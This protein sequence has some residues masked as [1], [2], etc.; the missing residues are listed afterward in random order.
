[1]HAYE[2]AFR[3]AYK[4]LNK[5]QKQAVDTIEGPV[6]VIAGPGTGKTQVLSL[7][8]ANIL[9]ETQTPPDGILCLTFTN[10]GVKAMR[11]RLRG[12]IGGTA[13]R[14]VVSTFHTFGMQLIEEF[15]TDLGF[16]YA[17]TLID[18]MQSVALVDT[19]LRSHDW[20][21]IRTRS[22]PAMYFRDIKSL[23]SLLKR[24]RMTPETFDAE[25]ADEIHFLETDEGSIS[26][27]GPSKGQL[28]QEIVK[29]IESLKRTREIVQFY[30]LYEA[31][32]KEQNVFDYD[33]VLENL[34]KLVEV[35]ENA[36]AHIRERYLYVLVD[37][38][39]DSSGV[40]NEFL[41]CVW[42]DE[43]TQNVFVVGDD[44][45]LIYGFGGA[46][47]SYFEGFKQTFRDVAVIT[48]TDNYRS[49][50]RILNTADTLL[51][52]SLANAPLVANATGDEP[53]RLVEAFYPRD[54]ILC[55]GIEIKQHIE[56]GANPNEIAILVPKNAQVKTAVR[57]LRDMGIPAVSGAAQSL[58]ALP[59]TQSMIA[60]LETLAAPTEPHLVAKTLLDP[61]SHIPPLV[62]HAVLQKTDTRTLSL[63]SLLA[64][65]QTLGLFPEDDAV[66][67]WAEKLAGWL[68]IAQL[69]D[70]QGLVQHIGE[71]VFITTAS[72]HHVLMRRIEIVRTFVHIAQSQCER[73]PK[74]TLADFVLFL[75]RLE[76]YG[77]P[78]PLATFG[79]NAGV[80]V[81][82]LHGSKGLEFEYVWIAHMDERT[83]SGS[84]PM[85]FALPQSV[86]DRI[87]KTNDEVVKRQIY[88]AITR[89]KQFCTISYARTGMTGGSLEL[90]RVVADLPQ[91][92]FD[93]VTAEE[94]EA[95]I[96]HHNPA[97]YATAQGVQAENTT[98]KTLADL[99]RDEYEN[100]KVSVT[101]L[102][103]FFSC[104]WKW[105]FRSFLRLPE[106]PVSALALGSIVHGAIEQLLKGK[107]DSTAAAVK[108]FVHDKVD[109]TPGL[110][111]DDDRMIRSHA[112]TIINRW[113]TERLNAIKG[114]R[115]IE[116]AISYR[117][118]E[119]DHL[120]IT[121]K[122]DLL[123]WLD[124]GV[125][126]VTDF[127]TG[128]PKERREIEK[129]DE[130]GRM[131]DYMRQLAMYSYLLD[132]SSKGDTVVAESCLEFVETSVDAKNAL[133]QTVIQRDA[134]DR[135]VDDIREYDTSVKSGE[136]IHR[137]CTFKPF[138]G[139]AECPYCKLAQLY[140]KE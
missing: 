92:L 31:L 5:G 36:A 107:L 103:N 118:K 55:A 65:N 61:I 111:A 21:H 134:I 85:A 70:I 84:M 32:K 90:A 28:K 112:P 24:E 80:Q 132:R 123:E 60:I 94:T 25:I 23:I 29:K 78:I 130:E 59:E 52:S 72:E 2:T 104:P 122:I 58:F 129:H 138:K 86:E 37:E 113:I 116:K 50:Q 100:H 11:E 1:M 88:V 22:N 15:Y 62:A 95:I 83:V 20:E 34:V 74:M 99:V 14:V 44:R 49:T 68:A 4:K 82:T 26:S 114:S 96:M 93:S 117:D 3:E 41:K 67:V 45:Q 43:E 16:D 63:Q 17:P 115:E 42:G 97:V 48:L 110:L 76:E 27:R 40:Q 69:N 126:R 121:G 109:K 47:L 101:L 35:S 9:L 71:A 98:L 119:F 6:M 7:R 87:E 135:L 108:K 18:D 125:V 91:D 137:P 136:W 73:D 102:N 38:H 77:T 10:S 30:E 8:I 120:L 133:Y 12:Y 127:K 139:D 13:S 51:K 81:M 106:P 89:A 19:L 105:Y 128:K 57:I 39:Q 75:R 64:D 140:T 66:R 56:S 131:S 124:K 79:G 53:L 46:S 33:D 54:E